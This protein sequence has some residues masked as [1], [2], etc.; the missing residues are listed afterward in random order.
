LEPNRGT[1]SAGGP[2]D[3][4]LDLLLGALAFML[5]VELGAGRHVNAFSGDLNRESLAAFKCVRQ[6]PQLRDEL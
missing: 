6:P 3:L 2:L 1:P 5:D 4:E